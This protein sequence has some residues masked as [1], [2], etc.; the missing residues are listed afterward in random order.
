VTARPSENTAAASSESHDI[1]ASNVLVKI[2][3]LHKS[4]GDN[5]VLKG[6]DLEVTLGE[7]VVLLGPS[8]SGKSTLL[9]CINFL[10]EPEQGSIE[11]GGTRVVCG[12]RGRAY[13]EAVLAARMRCGMVFQDF[14][15]YPHMSVTENVV[16][17]PVHVTGMS[18]HEARE[19]AAALL[20]QVGLSDRADYFP[21][22]LSGGQ[23]QRVAIARALAMEPELMLF[24]E[25]TS[26]L[27]P[28]LIGD[29]LKVMK[30]LA[31]SGMTMI[32][33]TH[34]MGFARDVADR[35]IL[36]DE[37]VFVEQG[38]PEQL[39]CNPQHD[40]SKVFLRHIIKDN[41]GAGE[42]PVCDDSGRLL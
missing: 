11:V 36:M 32:V 16:E 42:P 18:T 30:D 19:K 8:G 7:V 22:Q 4:F 2:E 29:V 20:E 35:A 6:I 25:P 12:S 39:F 23:K 37:G 40:R 5:E 38:T 27:D 13:R 15:L 26:A 10:E 34:E 28:E 33:V 3:R 1:A 9:R 14:N 24:D 21:S 17:S 41:Q 31:A